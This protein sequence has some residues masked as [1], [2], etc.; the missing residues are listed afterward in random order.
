MGSSCLLKLDVTSFNWF[1]QVDET[2]WSLL[3]LAVISSNWFFLV[4]E[5]GCDF[6]VVETGWD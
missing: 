2:G 1:S 4:V 3:K 6:M 5:T